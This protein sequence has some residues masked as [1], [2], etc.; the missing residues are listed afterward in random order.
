[1]A[2]PAH[3]YSWGRPVTSRRHLPLSH[4]IT[5]NLKLPRGVGRGICRPAQHSASTSVDPGQSDFTQG[6]AGPPSAG[7]LCRACEM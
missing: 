4:V 7:L 6:R 1:M 2:K 3:S 5:R